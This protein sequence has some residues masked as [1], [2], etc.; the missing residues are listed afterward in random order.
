MRLS[1]LLNRKVVNESRQQQSRL[2]DVRA[3][4]VE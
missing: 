1:E 2:H 4:L 3:E